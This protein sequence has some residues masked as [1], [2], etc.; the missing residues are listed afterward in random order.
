MRS[1]I[2][3]LVRSSSISWHCRRSLNSGLSRKESLN[4]SVGRPIDK[5]M[6]TANFYDTLTK[7]CCRSPRWGE[8]KARKQYFQRAWRN[9]VRSS[10]SP[11]SCL[12]HFSPP[13]TSGHYN[14]ASDR[15][16]ISSL[17][18]ELYTAFLT[19]LNQNKQRR[20]Y[21][22]PKRLFGWYRKHRVPKRNSSDAWRLSAKTVLLTL[23]TYGSEWRLVT[24]GTGDSC[25]RVLKSVQKWKP[26]KFH[27]FG[28]SE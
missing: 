21:L 20:H 16:T 4:S 12:S 26:T 15:K 24:M 25:W 6:Y 3:L 17:Y 14:R 13:R 9:L 22:T 11:F 7:T 2:N 27:G 10:N 28:I 8:V 23:S 1:F 18:N 5:W 19:P